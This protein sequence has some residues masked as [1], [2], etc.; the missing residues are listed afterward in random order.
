MIRAMSAGGSPDAVR[1][2]RQATALEALD[3]SDKATT[4]PR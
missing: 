3:A 1:L 2:E 4:V